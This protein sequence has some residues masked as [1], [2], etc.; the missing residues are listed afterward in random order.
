MMMSQFAEVDAK[1]SKD[2]DG[3]YKAELIVMV[4]SFRN[5]FI[6]ARQSLL[7]PEE[8]EV[9]EVMEK[10]TQ[11]ALSIIEAYEPSHRNDAEAFD[12]QSAGIMNISR[13]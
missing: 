10:A 5:E 6:R 11:S 8:S 1:L 9:V 13:I 7:S 12:R 4:K 3:S 2:V